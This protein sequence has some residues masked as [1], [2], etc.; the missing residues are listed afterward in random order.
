MDAYRGYHQIAMEENIEKMA[1]ITPRVI[2]GYCVMPFKL[3]NVGATYQ[4][5]V[6]KMFQR[7]LGD[8]MAYIDD[9]VIKSKME[10][11]HLAHLTEVLSI[12]RTHKLRLNTKKCAFEVGSGKFLGYLVTH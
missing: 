9:M 2:Y 8:T 3:K 4:Q 10:T 12:L 11:D 7:Q 6:S 5:M 1:F